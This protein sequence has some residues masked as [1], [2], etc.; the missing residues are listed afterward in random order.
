MNHVQAAQRLAEI[1][2]LEQGLVELLD[3]TIPRLDDV[4]IAADLRRFRAMHVQHI[5]RI[6]DTF[7]GMETQPPEQIDTGF[8]RFV[9]TIVDRAAHSRAQDELYGAI[10]GGERSCADEYADAARDPVMKPWL[11]LIQ[12]QGEDIRGQVDFLER[13]VPALLQLSR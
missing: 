5:D 7:L 12:R 6:D 2:Y 4:D 8:E 10:L 1:R 11:D 13:R 9:R 3:D